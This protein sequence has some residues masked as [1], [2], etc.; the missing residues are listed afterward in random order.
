MWKMWKEFKPAE[1]G[2]AA[3]CC[4]A[5]VVGLLKSY[6][7]G[8]RNHLVGL[9]LAGGHTELRKLWGKPLFLG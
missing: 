2:V 8:S 4:L 6:S 1:P 3:A 9:R 7:G 5:E